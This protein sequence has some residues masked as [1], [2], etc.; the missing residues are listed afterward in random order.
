M[1]PEGGKPISTHPWWCAFYGQDVPYMVDSELEGLTTVEN[2][3]STLI[4]SQD[5]IQNHFRI[6]EFEHSLTLR[7]LWAG[8]GGPGCQP[9]PKKRRT[10]SSFNER[11]E[12]QQ[13]SRRCTTNSD[14]ITALAPAHVALILQ[15]LPI[16]NVLMVS[17]ALAL[18]PRVAL[19]QCLSKDARCAKDA[20]SNSPILCRCAK[21]VNSLF[22]RAVQSILWTLVEPQPSNAP[23]ILRTTMSHYLQP[24]YG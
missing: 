15:C 3:A 14:G 2:L 4:M 12:S 1:F 19:D 8:L 5:Q 6:S 7:E 11:N 9:E 22:S 21:L 17:S 20:Q 24:C 13:R 10:H 16:K 18:S 23:C